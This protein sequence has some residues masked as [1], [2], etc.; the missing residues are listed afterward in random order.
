[1]TSFNPIL[2]LDSTKQKVAFKNHALIP[3]QPL[4]TSRTIFAPKYKGGAFRP[5]RDVCYSH[6]RAAYNYIIT[7]FYCYSKFSSFYSAKSC[8]ILLVL[9]KFSSPPVD[10]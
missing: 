10:G 4:E 8:G 7:S 1:M 9:A 3:N 5:P 2:S 6:T